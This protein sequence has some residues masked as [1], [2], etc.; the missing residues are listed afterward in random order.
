MAINRTSEELIG[1]FLLFDKKL[2]VIMKKGDWY[3]LDETLLQYKQ[4][5]DEILGSE[6][7]SKL[8]RI[9]AYAKIPSTI[10]DIRLGQHDLR[11]AGD[12]L[13]ESLSNIH[14]LFDSMMDERPA[15]IISQHLLYAVKVLDEITTSCIVK[16]KAGFI[17]LFDM[18]GSLFVQSYDHLS[19]ISPNSRYLELSKPF[20]DSLKNDEDI[21]NAGCRLSDLNSCVDKI[22]RY[23][24][25]IR[26]PKVDEIV[27]PHD[28][29][30]CE[31]HD[32]TVKRLFDDCFDDAVI[33]YELIESDFDSFVG[34]S[35]GGDLA[36]FFNRFIK[37]Y[38][39]WCDDSHV[40]PVTARTIPLTRVLPYCP[41]TTALRCGAIV[42]H[43]LLSLSRVYG[44]S[45]EEMDSLV[46]DEKAVLAYMHDHE[47][48]YLSAILVQG[49]ATLRVVARAEEF[50]SVI[51]NKIDQM[52]SD[53]SSSNLSGNNIEEIKAIKKKLIENRC[54]SIV[55]NIEPE[56]K[57]VNNSSNLDSHND[58]SKSSSGF[59]SKWEEFKFKL[60]YEWMCRDISRAMFKFRLNDF[61]FRLKYRKY[62]KK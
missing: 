45:P 13:F 44:F 34:I 5:G 22:N 19:R 17:A 43:C 21:V 61:L 62:L 24:R 48:S 40:I 59:P 28:A 41:L 37:F 4:L 46:N 11:A 52:N 7:M 58:D 60:R 51:R 12:I 29:F 47:K 39:K 25:V 26:P 2:Q 16:E 35:I 42:R 57:P 30:L 27:E 50:A 33:K 55:G 53:E 36:C 8:D 9:I 38:T 3:K 56:T 32:K 15:T 49:V 14:P 6:G 54:L 20:Y 23:W 31:Q 10:C 18:I 1:Q